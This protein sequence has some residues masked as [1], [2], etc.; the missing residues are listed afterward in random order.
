[1][2][3]S[4]KLTA[5]VA[6]SN[7]DRCKRF[8]QEMLGLHLVTDDPFALTFECSGTELR[9]QKVQKLQPHPFTALGW[10][11]VGM[12]DLVAALAAKG[13][14]F[15]RYSF[16]PQDDRGIWTAPDGTQVAWFKDPDGNLL[17]LSQSPV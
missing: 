9:I 12:Y 6:T 2:L 16:L 10:K 13:V 3:S 4:A 14:A 7:P 17:S 11:I 1:M 5:F 8:Y 15:E